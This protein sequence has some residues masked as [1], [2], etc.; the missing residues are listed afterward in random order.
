MNRSFYIGVLGSKTQMKGIDVCSNNIANINNYG[1][2]ADRP[3]FKTIF[4][5]EASDNFF[6]PTSNDI[7]AGA[8]LQ[9]TVSDLSPGSY[10]QTD[11]DFDMAI[12]GEGWFGVMNKDKVYFTRSGSFFKDAQGYLVDDDGNYLMGTMAANFTD[13]TDTI[14]P[15]DGEIKLKDV[16]N[17]EKI[18]LPTMLKMQAKPTTFVEIKG[19]LDPTIKKRFDPNLQKDVEVP[20]IEKYSTD[21]VAPNGEKNIL[22]ITFEKIVPQKQSGVDWKATFELADSEG[23]ILD[24]SE[25]FLSFNEYG[26]LIEANIPT[27]NNGSSPL[28]IDLGTVYSP[29]NPNGGYDGIVSH[30]GASQQKSISKD[31]YVAGDLTGYDVLENGEIIA[32]FDNGKTAPIAKVAIYHFQND[33]GLHKVTPTIYETTPNSGEPKFYKDAN[34]NVIEESKILSKT[35]ETSN[36]QLSEALTR[37]IVMQKAFDANAKSITTSD[38]MIQKAINMKK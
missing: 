38:Q 33:Q 7:S 26:A 37:L 6:D 15:I 32:A 1:F 13:N 22:N 9:T 23:R 11:K 28:K 17:Q 35:L 2:K 8:V 10:M 36:V 24:S 27:L 5:T 25:G 3:E 30:V 34:G 21:I 16:A 29:E 12:A 20:N 19:N 4:E 14:S 31:G 18:Q